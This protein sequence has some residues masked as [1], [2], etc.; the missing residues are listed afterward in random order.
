METLQDEPLDFV[1]TRV[2][3]FLRPELPGIRKC[4]EVEPPASK[5][6]EQE[7]LGTWGDQMDLYTKKMPEKF[8]GEGQ[9]PHARFGLGWQA[10]EV[11]LKFVFSQRMTNSMDALRLLA[12]VQREHPADVR[13]RF[14][15]AVARKYFAEGRALADHGMLLEAAAEAGVPT[16]GLRE[17]LAGSEGT[18]EIQRKYAEIFYGWGYTS[19]PVTL[20][21]CEGL[22]QH[23][24]GSQNLEAYLEVF[25]RIL[26]KPLPA[27]APA[28]TLPVWE[29]L[30]RT[31][32]QIGTPLGR[33]FTVEADEIFFGETAEL[34]RRKK[35]QELRALTSA[36]A[37]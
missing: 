18:F 27:S 28:P 26:D 2:P 6:S 30:S 29:K 4:G 34:M 7:D 13:E 8:G 19:V 17:W 5:G 16:E 10:A 25:Q 37:A 32:L 23:I 24:E 3:F 35:R 31:A 11:G 36:P 22:D 1:I 9:P 12:K 21:S 20:V 15:E 14:Y 33:D